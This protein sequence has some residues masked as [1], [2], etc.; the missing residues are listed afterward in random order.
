MPRSFLVRKQ[1]KKTIAKTCMSYQERKLNEDF[2]ASHLLKD[3]YDIAAPG[4]LQR[5]KEVDV[6]P[7]LKFYNFPEKDSYDSTCNRDEHASESETTAPLGFVRE[8]RF[9]ISAVLRPPKF[10]QPLPISS[11]GTGH[12]VV[13]PVLGSVH[14][15]CGHS[16]F[17]N[18]SPISAHSFRQHE[19]A[20]PASPQGTNGLNMSP[21]E[22]LCTNLSPKPRK[23]DFSKEYLHLK[24]SDALPPENDMSSPSKPDSLKLHSSPFPGV[25]NSTFQPIQSAQMVVSEREAPNDVFVF[26]QPLQDGPRFFPSLQCKGLQPNNAFNHV[27][28]VSQMEICKENNSEESLNNLP[29]I[30]ND[31]KMVDKLNP[32]VPNIPLLRNAAM[33]CVE[34]INAGYGIKNPLLSA[35]QKGCNSSGTFSYKDKDEKYICRICQKSFNIQRLLNRHLKCHSEIKRY[36]CT[37]CGKGFNDTFDLKR[38][39][40][41]HT[42]VRPYKCDMCEKAFTQRCSLESHGKKVHSIE[43]A[44]Q[45]KERRTKLYVCED[46]G[47]ST[48]EPG[49]HYIHLKNYHPHSPLL[50]KFYDKRQFKFSDTNPPQPV[51]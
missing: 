45:Y 3:K 34:F 17:V 31:G 47:H 46:C 7:R 38:H 44:F 4:N 20:S 8:N 6:P 48:K 42:G 25:F 23:L 40:R 22:Q 36:L 1:A 9:N 49:L 29:E 39:T 24:A 16:G 11:V 12:F 41:T 30:A 27:P 37:F 35:S 26:P 18:L 13:S 15:Y 28:L 19:L 5:S 50:T 33:K 43:L 2:S 10:L 51:Y 21:N 14:S 32:A